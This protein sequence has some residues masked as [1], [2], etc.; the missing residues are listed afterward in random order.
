MFMS[1]IFMLQP[2]YLQKKY[3]WQLTDENEAQALNQFCSLNHLS[4]KDFYEN[5]SL[6]GKIEGVNNRPG[7]LKGKEYEVYR[8][9][10]YYVYAWDDIGG[11]SADKTNVYI[12]H[13]GTTML[14]WPFDALYV[15]PAKLDRTV[16]D[17]RSTDSS[18]SNK[19]IIGGP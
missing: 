13:D 6:R 3:S 18:W 9:E 1:I 7:A 2:L 17:L 11:H 16:I 19:Y 4:L 15:R 10:Q 5:G 8:K 14:A 12:Q